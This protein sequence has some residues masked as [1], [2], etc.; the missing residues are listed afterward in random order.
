MS[1]QSF[2]AGLNEVFRTNRDKHE[3]HRRAAPLL[4]GAA[5]DPSLVTD[6]LRAHIRT[7]GSLNRL[8]YPVLAF[9]I[10]LNPFFALSMNAWVALPDGNTDLSTKAIHHHG[11][12][13]LSSSA[14]FGPGYEHWTFSTPRLLDGSDGLHS[15]RLTDRRVHS[16][17]KVAFVDHHIPHCPFYPP[18]LS[19][20]LALWSSRQPA[21]WK[22]RLKRF[23]PFK[24]REAMFK[25]LAMK[26]GLTKALSLKVVRD[27]DFCPAEAGFRAMTERVE[28]SLGPN[29][30]YLQ[31]FMHIV[32]ATG[33]QTLLS[34]L[35]AADRRGDVRSRESLSRLGADLRSDKAI[36][37]RLAPFHTDV[38][39]FNF[40]RADVE[41]SLTR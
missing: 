25:A 7:P 9:D 11:D 31:N 6:I 10:E 12:M 20:T 13:L 16:Q 34:E 15:L 41:R 14:L 21:N 24:G 17:G 23:P 22:D 18:S 29:E 35:D 40:T 5:G 2:L 3:A 30:D 28:F 8:H 26:A 19:L 27:F 38:A 37:G 36:P 33:N 4:E 32:Q 39:G 1:L